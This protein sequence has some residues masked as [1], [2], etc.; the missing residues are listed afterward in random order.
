MNGSPGGRMRFKNL[1]LNLLAAL[2]LLLTERNVSRAAEKMRITQSAMSNAL[3]RLRQYF[4]DDLLVKVGRRLELTPRA[5]TLVQP[6]RD[7]LVRIEA[8]VVTL[9]QFSPEVTPR[10]F[11]ILASDYTL[12]TLVPE[13]LRGLSDRR[14]TVNFTFLP[15]TDNPDRVLERGEADLLII[16]EDYASDEHPMVVLYE[17]SFVCLVDADHPRIGDSLDIDSFCRERHV[18]MKPTIGTPSFASRAL[19]Q[20][21]ISRNA[22]VATFSFAAMPDLIRGTQRL[23]VVHRSLG[24]IAAERSG[25]R[26]LELPVDLP[27]MR[28]CA[29][30]HSYRSGDPS[31]LWLR[32]ELE[33]AA[34]KI[35]MY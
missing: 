16:P 31:I 7:I 5:E 1:D 20:L 11:R 33:T 29:Q 2:D 34:R 15:Q 3:A 24:A 32:Q 35:W 4:G 27:V 22:D 14:L 26:I 6:V 30:W 18:V 9:P 23:A 10:D 28:Q 19:A 12:M 8:S 13:L 21:G 25:L 17:E